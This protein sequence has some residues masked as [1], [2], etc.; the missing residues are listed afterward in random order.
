M[1]L[2]SMCAQVVAAQA[3]PPPPPSPLPTTQYGY[4]AE[5]NLTQLVEA[6]GV[7]GFGYVTAHTYDRLQRRTATIDALGG[8]AQYGYDS[9]DRVTRVIDPRNLTTQY[10][11]NGLGDV[12]QLVSP[13]TGTDSFTYDAGGQVRTRTSANGVTATYG[14]DALQ[15]PMS[16]VFSAKSQASRTISW[17]YDEVG[18]GFSHGIGR[19]TS[20]A[21]PEGSTQYA[22]NAQGQVTESVQRVNAAPGTNSSQL[23]LQVGYEYGAA[24]RVARIV[25]PSGRVATFTYANGMLTTVSLAADAAAVPQ[26]LL[27]NI[28]NQPFGAVRAWQWN[29]STGPQ[30]H[31]RIFDTAGRVVRYRMGDFWRDLSYDAAGRITG[32]THLDALAGT[33][34]PAATALNQAFRYDELGRLT[35]AIVNAATWSYTYD[36]NGNRTVSTLN[37]SGSTY[38]TVSGS[39]RLSS[40]TNPARNFTFD[41]SGNTLTDSTTYTATYLL[42]GR[43]GTIK[44][45]GVTTTYAYDGF[46]RRVRKF[47]STAA[48]S[49]VVFV[50]DLSGHLLGEYDVNGSPVREYVWLGELPVATFSPDPANTANPPLVYYIHA[51]HLGAPRVVL[52]RAG[53][54]RWRWLSDPFAVTAAETNP[55]GQGTFTFNLRL[56]GQYYDIESSLHYNLHRYYDPSLDRYTQG[57]PIG[58]AGGLNTYVYVAG[59]PVSLI[60]PQGLAIFRSGSSYSDIPYAGHDW[61]VAQT[62]GDYITRWQAYDPGRV[63]DDFGCRPSSGDG[64]WGMPAP[65]FGGDDPSS[66]GIDWGDVGRELAWTLICPECKVLKAVVPLVRVVRRA[67]KARGLV[68]ITEHRAAHILNRHRAGTGISG[69]TEFPASWSDKDILHHV[70]DVATDPRSTMGVGK[71]NSP[72]AIGTRDGVTIRVDFYPPNHPTY[73]GKV[74]TAYPINV[75]PNP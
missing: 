24:G 34:S 42:E 47:S 65:D 30:Q 11:R 71:W 46:G 74:S 60:D 32:Y 44:R 26:P 51:D 41:T 31:D 21:F 36:A 22:Y 16:V 56:P 19:L 10:T 38:T 57:D 28:R 54:M 45:G 14:R 17:T 66:P 39:N 67:G 4:D 29:L 55:Q 2:I 33:A 1:L 9:L 25:Y 59:N 35:N 64:W 20:T 61:Q 7:S 63:G 69:K 3:L 23:S 43:L 8:K 52:D 15:R 6:P 62:S 70:S 53:R 72:F 68:D 13:D 50:H 73:A 5:G 75:A 49:T 18:P 12:T 58:L 27:S 48:S 37:G 40:L